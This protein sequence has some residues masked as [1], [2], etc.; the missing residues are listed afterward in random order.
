MGAIKNGLQYAKDGKGANTETKNK[1]LI[2][3]NTKEK[4]ITGGGIF[5]GSSYIHLGQDTIYLQKF[6]VTSTTGGELFWHQYMTNVLAP[7]SESKS[8]YKGYVNTGMLDNTMSFIIPVYN[9]MPETPVQNPN[10][11]E[12]DFEQDNTKVYADVSNTL[13]IRTGPS[14]S[15]ESLT[16]VNRSVVMTRIAKGKQ[17]GELWDRVKLPNGIQGY[18]FQGYLKE[19]P[20]KQIEQIYASIENAII[21]KGE[22]RKI[23]IEILPEEAKEHEV[24]Y[25]SSNEEVATVDTQGNVLG[26]TSGSAMITIKARENNVSTQLEIQVYTPVTDL[27]INKESLVLQKEEKFMIHAIIIPSDASNQNI[28]YQS[29]DSTIAQVDDTGMIM[30]I[31]EGSTKIMVQTEDNNIRKEVQ[32]TVLPKLSEN[33]IMFDESLK[34]EQNEI[35]GWN[36]ENMSV[37]NIKEKIDTKYTI[38]VYDKKENLLS[39][40]QLAGTGAKIRIIDENRVIKMEYDIILYGDVNGDAK[41]NSIDLLVLQRHILEIEKL[42][43]VFLKAGNISKNGKNPNSL[44]SLLI[45]RHIL[46]LKRI[47]Q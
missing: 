35:T 36:I 2:P 11:L 42:Q 27:Q 43:G 38:E 4:A 14:T 40:G 41:I 37:S 34:V 32:I 19:V 9:N 5:I 28:S 47:E 23:S 6:H 46:E 45:Q 24:V 33:E 25:S 3:W 29:E 22:S 16:T 31:E 20:E 30:A 1:Y 17:T 15:Y 44:D 7:Y 10:I 12:S 26:I 21:P 39:D 13:N 18:A 8:I